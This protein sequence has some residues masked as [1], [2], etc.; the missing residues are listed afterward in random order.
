[1]EKKQENSATSWIRLTNSQYELRINLDGIIAMKFG[2]DWGN[3]SFPKIIIRSEA[4]SGLATLIKS[5]AS[6]YGLKFLI[7]SARLWQPLGSSNP[8]L[9]VI[10]QLPVGSILLIKNFDKL[11]AIKTACNFTYE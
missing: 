1:M 5:V 2:R 8:T 9:P 4:G 3:L 10:L 7:Q 6:I 11:K